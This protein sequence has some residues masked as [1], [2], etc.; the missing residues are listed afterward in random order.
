MWFARHLTSNE[1]TATAMKKLEEHLK[2][3]DS[4]SLHHQLIFF[5]LIKETFILHIFI[6]FQLFN[7][8]LS[9]V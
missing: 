3:K 6:C 5:H 1:V 8:Q 9:N 7:Q 4:L 2:L